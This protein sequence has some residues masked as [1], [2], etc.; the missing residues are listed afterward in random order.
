V[1]ASGFQVESNK[2]WSKF[3]AKSEQVYVELQ[4]AMLTTIMPKGENIK[5]D[6]EQVWPIPAQF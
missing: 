2:L 4:A 6:L 5:M 3:G 1:L